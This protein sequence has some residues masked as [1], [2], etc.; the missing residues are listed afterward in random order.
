METTDP[1]QFCSIPKRTLQLVIEH[2]QEQGF[3]VVG[4]TVRDS[5]IVFD[6]IQSIEELPVG[7]W[8]EQEGG[9]YR[10]I[11]GATEAWF[12]YVVGPHSLK[13]YTFPPRQT[14]LSGKQDAQGQWHFHEPVDQSQPIAIIGVRACDLAALSIQDRIFMGDSYCDQNY[15]ARRR[16][17]FLIA[18]NC[19]RSA[20]TCFCHSMDCGPA[21][22]D[23][24]GFDMALTEVGDDFVVQV[25]S[26]AGS[27]A[28]RATQPTVASAEQLAAARAGVDQLAAR[29]ASRSAASHTGSTVDN[30]RSSAAGSP[31][32][33]RHLD[34]A[35]LRDLLYSNLNH[36][37]WD[38]VAKRCLSCSNCTMVCPTCFCSTIEDVPSLDET[39]VQRERV[40]AS[41]FT[42][43]HSFMSSGT[44]RQTTR[45]RY[46]QWLTHKLGG[47]I[48]QF[49][50]SG[51]VG[52]GRC[53]T[54]CPVGIDLTEE[55]AA[56][57][58][59]GANDK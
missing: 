24:A 10:I 43:N 25:G 37:H 52:C 55:V 40:W 1:A 4:P 6:E 32:R 48:D 15:A 38:E 26:P 47:W 17:M 11:K 35:G 34:T 45:S 2:L 14:V 33:Q 23:G 29:M 58:E 19:Q 16:R 8:D 18:V 28:L 27:I 44:V 22:K 31:S 12:E 30:K 51:C 41:C 53:I 13:N 46:R 3:R 20:P 7:W 21:V 42:D 56:L 36:P 57:R 50:T 49:G 59:S 54:W 39:E 9:R 5:A